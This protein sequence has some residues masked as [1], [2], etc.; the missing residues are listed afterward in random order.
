MPAMRDFGSTATTGADAQDLYAVL[1]VAQDA[2]AAEIRRA[3]RRLAT[4]LHPDKPGGDA[5][6]FRQLQVAYATL[7]DDAKV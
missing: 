2:S 4:S 6:K 5:A 3:Y 7:S 1:H